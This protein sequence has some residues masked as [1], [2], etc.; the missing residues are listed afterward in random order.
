MSLNQTIPYV[1]TTISA[2][3]ARF[4][5]CYTT[6]LNSTI[7]NLTKLVTDDIVTSAGGNY[8]S[9]WVETR[10][11]IVGDIVIYQNQLFKC[12][13][14]N[15]GIVPNAADP[16]QL[17]WALMTS[18]NAI[19]SDSKYIQVSVNQGNDTKA[20]VSPVPFKTLQAALNFATDGS[21]IT[22]IDQSSTF[23]GTIL[24]TGKNNITIDG[25]LSGV[26]QNDGNVI[27]SSTAVSYVLRFISCNNIIIK[28]VIL[29]IGSSTNLLA[30]F[31]DCTNII[32]DN[33]VFDT[34]IG[35]ATQDVGFFY[36]GTGVRM[37]DVVIA[38][39]RSKY[40]LSTQYLNITL[41]SSGT[42]TENLSRLFIL[43][44]VGPVG[45]ANMIMPNTSLDYLSA[46]VYNCN[47][48]IGSSSAN[49]GGGNFYYSNVIFVS[50]FNSIAS[51]AAS[52][53][54]KLTIMNSTFLNPATG[55]YSL[56]NKTGTCPYVLRD[57]DYDRT[58]LALNGTGTNYTSGPARYANQY[59]IIATTITG[60]T[61]PGET[62]VQ[63]PLGLVSS[64]TD[65][66][67]DIINPN[68]ITFKVAGYYNLTFVLDVSTTATTGNDCWF[69]IWL[70][71]PTATPSEA[72]AAFIG[73][74][75]QPLVSNTGTR[76][77]VRV[78]PVTFY[79]FPA[80]NSVY[81]IY[82]RFLGT[83]A[84]TVRQIAGYVTLIR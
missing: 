56:L 74:F 63:L 66:I 20:T 28:N 39:C 73:G 53:N 75:R 60:V 14:N 59:A 62:V 50:Q 42:G 21:K 6:T 19:L 52:T 64:D 76:P 77:V 26:Y 41:Q 67:I 7:S 34:T 13:V 25:G 71:P 37:G 40:N 57:C 33:V 30:T 1:N 81:S 36:A 29:N 8:L 23:D 15:V 65:D 51:S 49:H 55:T 47:N 83:V 78:T 54:N 44:H 3:V 10:S 84:P 24:L 45:I 80:V 11:Y 2:P 4:A 18:N 16:T 79:I 38:N 32:F 68:E 58:Q 22:L 5:E 17:E 69:N 31:D 9:P 82:M 46:Y 48:Y 43:N 61:C 35:S 27:T 70:L 72:G 12:L